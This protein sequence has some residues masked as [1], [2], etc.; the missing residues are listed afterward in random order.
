M[1]VKRQGFSE[2]KIPC[3]TWLTQLN[4]DIFHVL[5]TKKAKNT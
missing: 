1:R 5:E 4:P 3:D 2:R